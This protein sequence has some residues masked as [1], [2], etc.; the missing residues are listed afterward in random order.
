[1][2]PMIFQA[3]RWQQESKSLQYPGGLYSYASLSLAVRSRF[4]RR[5]M[6]RVN[7][8]VIN[9]DLIEDVLSLLLLESSSP[10][11]PPTAQAGDSRGD[12]VNKKHAASG[13]VLVFMPGIGE[14]RTLAERLTGSRF[15]GNR[16]IFEIVP[17]HST[18]S[19]DDQ[20]RAFKPSPMGC[21]KII[22]STN[23]AETSVT[24]PDVV[25]VIDCGRVREIQRDKRTATRKL[26][27]TWC[28]RA[29][30]KQR[31]GRA[32]RV[33]AGVCLKLYSSRTES[34]VMKSASEPE[35]RRIPL[36]EV[37]LTI[38]AG[39]FAKNCTDFL[40][41]TPQPPAEDA[42]RSALKVL[43]D[44][45]A[46][47][48][49]IPADT[50]ISPS[51]GESLTA[52]GR[53]LAK[54]PVDARVG[55]MLIFGA[56]FKC[57]DAILTIAACLSASKSPFASS[58]DDG[59]QM[60]AAHAQ[61]SLPFSDFL[62]LVNVWKAFRQADQSGTARKFCHEK[63]FN[64]S[65]LCEIQDAR[66]HYLD[67]LCG[68]GFIDRTKLGHD[69]RNRAFDEQKLAASVYSR[70]SSVEQVVHSVVCAG[71]YPNVAKL[72]RTSMNGEVTVTHKTERLFIHSSVNS[73]IPLQVP[74]SWVTFFEKFGT[75]RRVSISKT[76]FV[77]PFCL[78]L[79]GSELKVLHTER[80]V[81]IDDWI[82]L[83]AA[84]KTGVVFRE[85]RNRLDDLLTSVIEDS[86]SSDGD[87]SLRKR[88]D[89]VIDII[90]KLLSEG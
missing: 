37:C 30:A 84:A 54:L 17:L 27:A 58:F 89:D 41:Q 43:E 28:S 61:F 42:V 82:E 8:T 79:F 66:H 88:T 3:T 21:R 40:S 90:V 65:A 45:G 75:E 76:A 67:L 25:Y 69:P 53:H 77:S 29:S 16:K 71:L 22:I 49:R 78:M 83:P 6:D 81:L 70:Y 4:L 20:R 1:M 46:I 19:S 44:I 87:S 56:V 11:T 12:G 13:A 48:S 47:V 60:K 86:H 14:I 31:S 68:L 34:Q 55:K 38:L 39:G 36:E 51:S 57:T 80:K 74:S 64:Y 9:Y 26:V 23:V 5:S 50:P 35:L 85:I 2:S 33:Q 52:L 59:Q 72:T 73:K 24:I 62:T 63:F 18:L 32:G 7:E 15:F 10:F